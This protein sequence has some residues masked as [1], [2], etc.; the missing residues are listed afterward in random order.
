LIDGRAIARAISAVLSLPVISFCELVF[1]ALVEE[2]TVPYIFM[3]FILHVVVPILPPLI[4]AIS[5][6][7]G[8]FFVSSRRDRIPLFIPGI[9]S[10]FASYLLFNAAGYT[11]FAMLELVS[12]VSSFILFVISFWWKISIHLASLA[13]PIVFFTI[14][15]YPATL[16]LS[17][18]LP[19]LG[20]ARVRVGAHNWR[21]VLAGCFVGFIS[22]LAYLLM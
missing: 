22:T 17:P 11:V 4:Y 19:L 6:R 15:G 8:D 12:F 13:I 1:L 21:Q 9:L 16:L 20:W 7:K 14:I 5:Y 10:Y 2:F 18:L 3:G